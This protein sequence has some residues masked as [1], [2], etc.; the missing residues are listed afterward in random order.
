[1]V[2]NFREEFIFVFFASQ[3]LFAKIKTTKFAVPMCTGEQIAFQSSTNSHYLAILAPRTEGI[4]GLYE[5][6]GYM[7][8][9]AVPAYLFSL[10]WNRELRKRF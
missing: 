1:M 2:S 6:P 3:E 8:S 9:L 10:Y 7:L 5:Y 4:T